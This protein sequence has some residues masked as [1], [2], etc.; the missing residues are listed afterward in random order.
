[1][2]TA[3][4]V[5]VATLIALAGA[6]AF[7][8]LHFGWFPSPWELVGWLLVFAAFVAAAVPH[9][10]RHSG[11]AAQVHGAARP[12]HEGEAVEA[13]RGKKNPAYVRPHL[14]RLSDAMAETIEGIC[15]AG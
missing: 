8:A 4:I 13:A 10:G 3:G 9:A 14:S 2:D 11:H 5:I 12:A 7:A 1:M 6:A 15:S